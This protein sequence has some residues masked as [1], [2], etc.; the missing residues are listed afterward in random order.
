MKLLFDEDENYIKSF[1][2]NVTDETIFSYIRNDLKG[3]E[4]FYNESKKMGYDF[5]ND[6]KFKYETKDIKNDNNYY[7]VSYKAWWPEMEEA[8]KNNPLGPS[9][10]GGGVIDSDAR[11]M[12]IICHIVEEK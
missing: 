9:L 7:I 12:E 1:P 6:P 11:V 3:D 5:R 8:L 2:N 4:I 10:F